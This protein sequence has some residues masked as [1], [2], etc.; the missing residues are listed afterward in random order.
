MS[1]DT[2]IL[3]DFTPEGLAV[4]TLNRPERHNAFNADIIARLATIFDEIAKEDAL[5][6]MIL[7]AEGPS[8]SAG[9][10]L[11]WM[12]AAADYTYD[13]NL[14]DAR[15]LADMLRRLNDLPLPT[16]ALVQGPAYGGGV[17][18]VSACDI[19]VAVESAS[20][21]FS[22]VRLGIVP[23]TISPYVID[24][25]GPRAA[26][27]YFLTG[28]R[29]DAAEAK[30]IG[31]VHEVVP[32]A[33]A[34]GHAGDRLVES[35]WQGAPGAIASAKD[36]IFAVAHEPIDEE[37]IEETAERIAERRATDEAKE[38]LEAFLAKR[39]PAWRD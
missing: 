29:F 24:A 5:R 35:I 27:R 38:G 2:P 30:R 34:L 39:K 22:E 12:R 17:G 18:L 33:A 32:D 7:R 14:D 15:A 6:A 8:F 28:E 9:A 10:D 11:D 26:R 21:A 13:D 19:A 25:I 23:A 36:L 31:L 4:V 1:E 20:F 16:I 3:A 37:T